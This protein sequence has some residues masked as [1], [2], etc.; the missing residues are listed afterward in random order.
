M[1]SK[2][3]TVYYCEHCG[4]H[5]LSASAMSVHERFCPKRPENR[6][7]CFKWCKHL[8]MTFAI[9][10]GHPEKT[11]T[12]ARIGCKLYSYKL[13]RHTFYHGGNPSRP[14]TL[15]MPLSC[16]HYVDAEVDIITAREFE[17]QQQNERDFE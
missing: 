9:N 3:K 11:F 10:G 1:K 12:C 15:R 4:R 6:H 7:E 2:T 14:G 8:K 17:R 5:M 16:P 13:E